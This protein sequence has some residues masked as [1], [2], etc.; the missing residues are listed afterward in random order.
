M[1]SDE[2]GSDSDTS[3]L[4]T[5]AVDAATTTTISINNDA[6]K[7]KK[8]GRPQSCPTLND[9]KDLIIKL[10]SEDDIPIIDIARRLNLEHGLDIS[11]RTIS[12][13]L[14]AWNVPRKK[15]RIPPTQELKERILF[16]YNKNL[17]DDQITKA[18]LTEGYDI[19]KRNLARMRQS[20]CQNLSYIF[21]FD[22]SKQIGKISSSPLQ[23]CPPPQSL[24]SSNCLELTLRFCRAWYA[25]TVSISRISRILR[26]RRRRSGR[27]YSPPRTQAETQKEGKDGPQ[28][29][30][31]SESYRLRGEIYEQL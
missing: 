22:L 17:N 10:F 7:S 23:F 12:R 27:R 26:W 4:A 1:S 8:R 9:Y 3:A 28:W 18:L 31:D 24:T 14:T 11:E 30:S 20:K 21:C 19:N 6:T 5:A 13:R 16:H 29:G 15:Q 2:S 25:K